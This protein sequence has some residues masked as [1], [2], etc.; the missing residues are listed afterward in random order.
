[1]GD[2]LAHGALPQVV[3]R[4]AD[5]VSSEVVAPEVVAEPVHS[6]GAALPRPPAR[7]ADLVPVTANLVD[8]YVGPVACSALPQVPARP[9][10]PHN[11]A[12]SLSSA[13]EPTPLVQV[14]DVL[15]RGEYSLILNADYYGLPPVAEGWVYMR[16]GLDAFRVDWSSH[17]VLER[18]TSEAA[19][20]F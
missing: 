7:P 14:G 9:E 5:L 8:C 4:L 2:R 18:V 10:A 13:S 16:V 19:A 12:G 17:E 1:M 6:L 3:A 11:P 20:N 15:P